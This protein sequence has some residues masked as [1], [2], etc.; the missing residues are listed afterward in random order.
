MSKNILEISKIMF[1]D[2]HKW[3]TVTDK[4]KQLSFFIY[5]RYF[6]KRYHSLAQLLNS[7]E[8]DYALGMDLIY[9]YLKDKPYPNWF[10]SKSDKTKDKNKLFTEKDYKKLMEVF[11]I[12]MD[13]V[14]ILIEYYPDIV[15]EELDYINKANK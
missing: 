15:K 4:E 10:W 14:E 9:H 8:M 2:R 1:K 13:E 6:S 5:N 12:K 3:N 7:K 11:S